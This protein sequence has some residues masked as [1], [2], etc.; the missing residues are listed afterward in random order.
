VL[1][2]FTGHLAVEQLECNVLTLVWGLSFL[3]AAVL[4]FPSLPLT[5]L[6]THTNSHTHKADN[7]YSPQFVI[8]LGLDTIRRM[9]LSSAS[10]LQIFLSLLFALCYLALFQLI[11]VSRKEQNGQQKQ[12]IY[13]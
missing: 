9:P 13:K 4:H 7:Q 2:Q 8:V 1:P 5:C 3:T 11:Y 10:P 6:V 12:T